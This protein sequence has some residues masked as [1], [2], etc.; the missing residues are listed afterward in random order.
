LPNLWKEAKIGDKLYIVC[1]CRVAGISSDN[2][3]ENG[4]KVEAHS[5]RLVVDNFAQ[6]S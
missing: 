6:L 4:K 3:T 5:V 1:E 2:Y